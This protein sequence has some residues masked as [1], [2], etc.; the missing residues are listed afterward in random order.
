MEWFWWWWSLLFAMIEFAECYYLC[1]RL[2]S[3]LFRVL[4]ALVVQLKCFSSF[5][6]LCKTFPGNTSVVYLI[7]FGWH[8]KEMP[9]EEANESGEDALF[10]S[11]FFC[12]PK[13]WGYSG[14]DEDLEAFYVISEVDSICF[15][16]RG[17]LC[18]RTL[19]DCN[20][21]SQVT[22]SWSF[23]NPLFCS[24]AVED[25]SIFHW[26]QEWCVLSVDSVKYQE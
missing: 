19:C 8:C 3:V 26:E 12:L 11:R 25:D 22:C 6:V 21:I 20:S 18:M 2:F 24:T 10:D 16:Q 13:S 14:L 17:S 7:F 5:L 9:A 4:L 23:V 1:V 15:I